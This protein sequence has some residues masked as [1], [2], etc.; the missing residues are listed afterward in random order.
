MLDVLGQASDATAFSVGYMKEEPESERTEMGKKV[1]K[2][3][4]MSFVTA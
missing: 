1:K 4:L 2:E 3:G